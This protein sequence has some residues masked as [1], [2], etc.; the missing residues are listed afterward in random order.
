MLSL[1]L[2]YSR[3]TLVWQ[4]AWLRSL[5]MTLPSMDVKEPTL[6]AGCGLPACEAAVHSAHSGRRYWRCARCGLAG[7]GL[8]FTGLAEPALARTPVVLSVT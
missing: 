5:A 6:R 1:W 2:A 3:T 8:D 4:A 7:I